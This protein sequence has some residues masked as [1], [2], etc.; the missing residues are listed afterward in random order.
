[1]QNKLGQMYGSVSMNI[2]P[3][4]TIVTIGFTVLVLLLILFFIFAEFSERF[5]VTGYVNST[6]A[7]V[8]VYPK[9][10]GFI[11]ERYHKQGD[12]VRKGEQLFLIDTSYAGYQ[13]N[14][15]IGQQL[16]QNKVFVE[17]EI[18][19]KTQYLHAMKALLEKKYISL[20]EYNAKKDELIAL[21]HRRNL[22]EMEMIKYQQSRSYLI[23]SPIDGMV[24]G[25]MFKK[26]QY[27]HAA[28]PLVKLIPNNS[29]LVA[30]LFVP[31]KQA[32]FLSKENK[33]MIRYDAYP[34]ERFGVYR[35][36]IKDISQS[37]LTDE[38]EEKPI[39][40]GEPYY[41]ITAKL[42]KQHVMVYGREKKIQHGM[43]L[44]AII[45]GSKRKAWQWMLDPLY[46]F[47]GMLFV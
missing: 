24:A 3:Q 12:S 37:I 30:E 46:S 29:E 44:S 18:T 25:A 39:R 11:I 20:M 15:E 33:V 43:T 6:K 1:M 16:K 2:P 13:Y 19:N 5:V 8:Q 31:A 35:A 47:Y 17:K 22:I 34:Y 10:N 26:G 28:K 14:D 41:K 9:T 38:D 45:V 7:A 36:V 42:E 27:A 32:G 23:R 40:I 4:Y 21:K